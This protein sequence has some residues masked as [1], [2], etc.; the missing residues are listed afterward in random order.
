MRTNSQ[1]YRDMAGLILM[2]YFLIFI[3]SIHISASSVA[4]IEAAFVYRLM[5][6]LPGLE[7]NQ[8]NSICIKNDKNLFKIM[9]QKLNGTTFSNGILNIVQVEED[10]ENCSIL[11]LGGNLKSSHLREIGIFL[12][13]KKILIVSKEGIN[14]SLAMIIL[15]ISNDKIKFDANNTLMQ[16][17]KIQLSSKV[18]R[19]A[20]EV[21]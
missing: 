16:T 3:I 5:F 14:K 8:E 20:D 15:K 18:I 12:E 13:N 2:R 6:F 17:F 7:N 4:S 9:Y 1:D 10:Y 21:Y 11:F 19:L